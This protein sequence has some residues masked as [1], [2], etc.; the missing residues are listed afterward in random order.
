MGLYL[1]SSIPYEAYKTI[2]LT[3]FFVDKTMLLDELLSSLQLNAQRHICI[4]RPR[5]FG[6]TVMANMLAAF[7]ERTVD[8]HD[9]FDRLAIAGSPN[10]QRHLNQY[11]VIFIDCSKIPRECNCYEQYISRIQNG[12]NRDLAAAFPDMGID[13]G[14]TVWDIFSGIFEKNGQKFVFVIDEWDALFHMPFISTEDQKAYLLFLKNL[15][16]DQVYVEFAYMTGVL[17][18]AKYSSG[19]ELNM[20]Q[21][22]DMA[23]SIKYSEYFGFLESEVGKLFKIYQHTANAP[24]IS[25]A[26]LAYWYNGYH[27][28]SGQRLYNPRS[29]I[30]ALT[31]NQLR[32]YWTNSGPY[33]EIFYY[34]RNNIEAIR[35]D[36]VLMVSKIQVRAKMLEYAATSS[37]LNTKDQIYSAM[38]IYG[39]LT[40]DSAT[41]QVFIPNKELMDQFNELLLSKDSLGYVYRLAR[42]SEKML[43][44]TLC[45]DTQT[46]A[47]ILQYAHNTEAPIFAYNSESELSAVVNL[48]YLAARDHYRVEREDKAGKGYVDFIFYPQ[49][50]HD[51]AIILELK[52]GNTPEEAIRQIKEKDY[53]LR[54]KGKLEEKGTYTGRILAVGIGYDKKTKE[55]SCRVE[56][57]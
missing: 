32:S 23:T 33:D 34:I 14:G 11:N 39:L 6:K 21:E 16:K 49:H 54:L 52:A 5:R 30:C 55:H 42:K 45:G 9:I 56:V 19:S 57:V 38:V 50:K 40:Y 35:D 24:N 43:E 28:A 26:D 7:L 29:V 41:G 15:L 13:I 25:E 3:D 44:A 2:A 46:M 8:S 20:F 27:T 1:N 18:I 31:D 51:D 36:L 12:V 37:D 4:T 47:D 48:V 22:Y 10:Y 17:P 53:A